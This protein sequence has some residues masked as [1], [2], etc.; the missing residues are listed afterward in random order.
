MVCPGSLKK[1]ID[2]C[3]AKSLYS[4][5]VQCNSMEVFL[6]GQRY[7]CWM[8]ADLARKHGCVGAL[9]EDLGTWHHTALAAGTKSSRLGMFFTGRSVLWEMLPSQRAGRLGAAFLKYREMVSWSHLHLRVSSWLQHSSVRA[10]QKCS[11]WRRLR[12][13]FVT[14][15]LGVEPLLR[16]GCLHVHWEA[17]HQPLLLMYRNSPLGTPAGF[18]WGTGRHLW[19]VAR[20][21]VLLHFWTCADAQSLHTV[22]DTEIR[23]ASV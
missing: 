23:Y 6:L 5:V 3:I 18:G 14:V 11:T 13:V 19:V 12:C 15:V 16:Q 20:P 10:Q 4:N 17:S 22:T 9:W 8:K 21:R 1:G 7:I 2:F